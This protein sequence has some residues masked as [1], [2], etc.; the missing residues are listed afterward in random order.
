M[1]LMDLGLVRGLVGQVL[2]TLAGMIVVMAIRLAAG[3]EAWE[4]ETCWVIGM[5]V[6]GLGF[7]IGVGSM[8]DWA[9][10]WIGK[11]TPM[12]HG[13]PLGKPAW[14]RYFG[15]D[16]N[17][18]IIGV[19]YGVTG[20]LMVMIGGAFAVVFRTELTRAGLQFLSENTYNTFLSVHGWATLFGVLIGVGG[21]ANYIVPLMLGAEDM[22]FPRLN[23]FAYW[24]NVPAIV[25]L[26]SSIYF[27]WDGGWTVYPPLSA[28]GP[29]G[30]QAIFLA[31]FFLGFSSI[32]GSLNL[33]ATILLMRP[34]G[35]SLFR[36]PIFCWAVLAT[37]FIQLTATQFI[38]Q[39]FLMVSV[40]RT[41]GMGF[42]DPAK[43]GAPLLFQHLF[44]FYSHPA[45]YVFVLPGL[46]IISELLP[47][48]ARK[49][50]FGYRWIALS[51]V[52]IA[53]IGYIVW[54]HHMF[55]SGFGAYLRVW[56]MLSTLLVAVPTGVKFFSWLGTLWGG[57]MEYP[58]PML[59]VLGAISVFLLG[60][61]SGPILG[62][63]VSDQPLHDSYFVVGHFHATLFGGFIFPF[64]A[65]IYYWYPKIS[66]RMYNETLG[67]VH[68]WIMTPAF[69]MMS[70]GQMTIGTMG[71]RR[72]IADYEQ[73]L[74]GMV[75]E[76]L[77][78]VEVGHIIVTISAFAIAF[79]ILLMIYNLFNSAEMGKMAGA[80]PWRSRSP[81]WQIPS[82][83]P[84]HSF[85]SPIRVVGE[86]YDYGLPGSYVAAAGAH[87]GDD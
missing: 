12:R 63:V 20:L 17:H 59:F 9:Q 76:S 66:G 71:M 64:I 84:E 13:G 61:L 74:G 7:L 23:A 4:T 43:G 32:L 21:M 53:L 87:A 46:G 31:V 57:R 48:F 19:Q 25:L 56:F 78:A 22:A 51:S 60:G 65:A 81:E 29:M 6:G 77:G 58:T 67:K 3:M 39:A 68:F 16:Y 38:A 18:K 70:L 24:I 55:T 33:I 40:Q 69:W 10:W 50:L 79:G 5:L 37:S 42:F 82:P 2:G 83:V 34:P 36:M 72:R 85:A 49:P 11:E 15:V 73:A 75:N 86:P 8:D 52:G 62:T 41:L 47:V 27:G 14:V 26:L 80:N 44:W 45:V 35:M 1:S 30:F 28:I 54:G